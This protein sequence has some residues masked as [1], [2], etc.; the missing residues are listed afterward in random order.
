MHPD[1]A[2]YRRLSEVKGLSNHEVRRSRASHGGNEITQK[3]RR[4]FVSKF[5]SNFGDPI[6]KILLAALFINI[7][8]SFKGESWFETVGIGIAILL[9][10]LVSTVSE[11]GSE[12]TFKKLQR[13]ASQI[14]CKVYRNDELAELPI[15]EIVVGDHVLLQAGD[16]IPADGYMFRGRISVDQ[17]PLNGESAEAEKYGA[18]VRRVQR[19]KLDIRNPEH[20]FRGSVVT[21]GEG[22]MIVTVVGD[23][24]FYGSIAGQVQEETRQSPLRVRL[25]HLAKTISA[26]G[27]A[28]AAAVSIAYMFNAVFFK[29]GFTLENF[30]DY[31][32]RPEAACADFF[33]AALLAVVVIV[34]AVP[35]GLPMMITVVLSSNMKRML[36]DNIL[37]RKLVSIETSGSLNILFTDKTGTLTQGNLKVHAFLSGGNKMYGSAEELHRKRKLWDL[38]SSCVYYNT[39]AVMAQKEGAKFAVGGNA[40]D[41][42][43]LSYVAA[44]PAAYGEA[45]I[46]SR[47]PFSSAAKYSYTQVKGAF[48]LTFIKGAPEKILP[49]CAYYY[50]E[51]L[52]LIRFNR[53]DVEGSMRSM[54]KDAMRLVAVA[55][56]DTPVS[57]AGGFHN[58]RLVGIFGIRDPIR[59][60][61]AS[62]VSFVRSAG[63]QVVMITGDSLETARAV[64]LEAGL[65]KTQKDIAITSDQMRCMTDRELSELLPSL[66]IVARAMPADKTRLIK[67]AQSKGLVVGMTGDGI[68]DAPALKKADVGFAM[69]SGAEIAKEA[70][71]I[72]ILDN[73]LK[74]IAKAVLYGRTIFK[75]IRKFIIFQLTVNLCAVSI[76]IIGPFIGA[77]L[78]VTVIQM[79]WINLVMDTLA[80]L[81]FGGEPPLE[82][83]MKEAP[84]KRDEPLING[85]MWSQIVFTG[86]Y[87]SV[88]GLIF[89]KAP[90]IRALFRESPANEYFLTG[91]FTFFLFAG[92]FN[93]FSARTHRLNLF[94]N[95]GRNRA[96]IRIMALVAAMQ[97][98][99]IYLGGPLFRT[100]D[101]T[102][103]EL[104][105]S[106]AL[107]FTVI[108]ADMARK[109]VMS[110]TRR[111]KST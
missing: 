29:R 107:A 47:A 62:G 87:T 102:F 110:K 72:V 95:I 40:T 92:L 64:A 74:S 93:S 54:A 59:P 100:S 76:S 19:P 11:Y 14:R 73:D 65:I 32:S 53:V 71:D 101:L 96:F 104:A 90:A 7:L 6:I 50:D 75:S 37:V 15:N 34:M 97:I 21:N 35:E 46:V 38:L 103:F 83:Y 49:R 67:I 82:Y 22:V 55:V 20:V 33:Q 86:L 3:K 39:E 4:G 1:P 60:D 80:G 28:S 106:L 85:Y 36:K 111:G 45:E 91:F 78:P 94:A 109:L 41:R 68:N 58:L 17:S 52:N 69:G 2:P 105:V 108:P 77:G 89:L 48:N 98:V 24:T 9:A 84:K 27:Y 42:A 66:R 61:A 30:L 12:Q 31:F 26:F 25:A 99:F 23:N 81:A 5:L 57:P 16:R 10:T 51:D 56:S 88:L 18:G 70:G 63:I 13:E 43:L 79:L 44:Y 8:I